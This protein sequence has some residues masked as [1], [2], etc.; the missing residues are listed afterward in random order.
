MALTFK[1]GEHANFIKLAKQLKNTPFDGLPLD[2]L[3]FLK[4][5]TRIEM[6]DTQ[7]NMIA[8]RNDT[9]IFTC[10]VSELKQQSELLSA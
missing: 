7:E 3:S 6:D 4:Q 5:A 1:S 2:A 9:V 10:S 8:F